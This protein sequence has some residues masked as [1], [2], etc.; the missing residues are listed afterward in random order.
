MNHNATI[1]IPKI[2]FYRYQKLINLHDNEEAKKQYDAKPYDRIP[3]GIASFDDE[4]TL[5][6]TLQ[7]DYMKNYYLSIDRLIDATWINVEHNNGNEPLES[8]KSLMINGEMYVIT[9]NLLNDKEHQGYKNPIPSLDDEPQSETVTLT[10]KFDCPATKKEAAEAI[11]NW[12]MEN[13]IPL[14]IVH[15]TGNVSMRY[16]LQQI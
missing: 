4:T 16:V 9:F 12:I 15:L 8:T 6:L 10:F 11:R 3:I 1:D 5:A 7:S 13:E 2:S 14:S